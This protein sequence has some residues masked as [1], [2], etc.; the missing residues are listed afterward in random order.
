MSKPEPAG[1]GEPA[2][3]WLS[4]STSTYPHAHSSPPIWGLMRRIR[5][6]AAAFKRDRDLMNS[7]NAPTLIAAN[8]NEWSLNVGLGRLAHSF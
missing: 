2:V 8:M 6:G 3:R 1:M 7:L 5:V 4:I